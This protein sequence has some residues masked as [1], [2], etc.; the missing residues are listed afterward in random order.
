MRNRNACVICGEKTMVSGGWHLNRNINLCSNGCVAKYI[1]TTEKFIERNIIE[2][3]IEDAELKAK[4]SERERIIKIIDDHQ[5]KN[6]KT[7]TSVWMVC[8]LLKKE[9]KGR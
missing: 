4:A 3:N 2:R 6:G 9:I 1:E 8:R 7:K 5:K